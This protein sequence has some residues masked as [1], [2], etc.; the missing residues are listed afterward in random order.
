M[1]II[2]SAELNALI[3]FYVHQLL[4]KFHPIFSS[5]V[6]ISLF[7]SLMYSETQ[8]MPFKNFHALF[9]L[10]FV[11]LQF[12]YLIFGSISCVNARNNFTDWLVDLLFKLLLI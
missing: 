7:Y 8:G 11:T 1:L 3:A 4:C 2:Y 9:I 5:Y 6:C 10:F 12:G